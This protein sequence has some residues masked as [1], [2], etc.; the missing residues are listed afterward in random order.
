MCDGIIDHQ[1]NRQVYQTVDKIMN[2]KTNVYKDVA[3]VHQRCATAADC[4]IKKGIL[5]KSNDNLT[6]IVIAIKTKTLS[7]DAKKKILAK[8]KV[9]VSDGPPEEVKERASKTEK[10][11]KTLR[12]FNSTPS[13]VTGPKVLKKRKKT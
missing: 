8:L 5:T 9:K 4:L 6:A 2:M 11:A 13:Q 3:T 7:K 10:H 12:I 1:T